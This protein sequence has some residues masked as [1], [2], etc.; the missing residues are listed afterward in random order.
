V[1]EGGR[2]RYRLCGHS[3][4]E[5]AVTE[6]D[7]P[8]GFISWLFKSGICTHSCRLTRLRPAEIIHPDNLILPN[9]IP[10]H[11]TAWPAWRFETGKCQET[12]LSILAPPHW[13]DLVCRAC[14]SQFAPPAEFFNNLKVT[15]GA[16][17]A[18]LSGL[19]VYSLSEFM[20]L[21][22]STRRNLS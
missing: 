5:F 13:M 14:L 11:L 15:E 1:L 3:T 9:G 7:A 19:R 22:A 4:G 10:G 18:L 6:L 16:A 2:G 12:L 17:L 8:A 20:T 21:D